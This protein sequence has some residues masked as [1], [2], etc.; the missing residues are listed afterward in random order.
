MR[1]VILFVFFALLICGCGRKEKP[2]AGITLEESSPKAAL[3]L[4]FVPT[5]EALPVVVADACGI[6]DEAGVDIDVAARE[7]MMQCDE[8][9]DKGKANM[10]YTDV[11]RARRLET[12]G[13]KLN[14]LHSF[15]YRYSLVGCRQARLTNVSQLA[16]KMVGMTR[17]SLSDS[18]CGPTA[19]FR[20]QV[21]NPLTRL[22]MLTSHEIDAAWFAEPW[23]EWAVGMGGN[24][25]APTSGSTGKGVIAVSPAVMKDSGDMLKLFVKAYNQA[26][27]SL[28]KNGVGEYVRLLDK[29]ISCPDSIYAKV[30]PRH[31]GRIDMSAN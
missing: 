20:I 27:D 9:Y 25:V 17:Y 2:V 18:L 29:Y 26:V 23:A 10:F 13:K 14:I 16:D 31:F 28:E 21:N 19:A 24:V 22:N 11:I 7:S 30:S 4:S 12:K 1:N 5:I 3:R 6:F 8:M 15:E